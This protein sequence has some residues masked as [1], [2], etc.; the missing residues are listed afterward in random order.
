MCTSSTCTLSQRPDLSDVQV[1]DPAF[2]YKWRGEAETK[3][4]AAGKGA[5]TDEQ[6]RLLRWGSCHGCCVCEKGA[7][8]TAA[9]AMPLSPTP[10][11]TEGQASGSACCCT[12]TH[13]R[14]HCTLHAESL[15]SPGISLH[16]QQHT[17]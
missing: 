5:M 6:V 15:L 8:Q 11:L 9:C 3:M 4:R 14:A 12:S 7:D 1:S 10:S 16:E 2:V 13:M 17:C